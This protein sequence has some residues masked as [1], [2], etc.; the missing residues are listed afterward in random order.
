VL[1][2]HEKVNR[3][4]SAAL[5]MIA[6]GLKPV[7]QRILNAVA[8]LEHM[9]AATPRRELVC[10]LAG[11]SNTTST[12]FAKAIS[13]LSSGGYITYPPGGLV[14]LTDAG[15]RVAQPPPRPRTSAELQSRIVQLLEPVCGRILD[16]L[17]KVYP[18]SLP[19]EEVARR[20]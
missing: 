19:R 1:A 17:V 9:G 20:A 14:A 2:E 10:F 15:R 4:R 13:G 8:E 6:N 7:Q 18:R 16:P 3:N 5:N 12:G 11:Y